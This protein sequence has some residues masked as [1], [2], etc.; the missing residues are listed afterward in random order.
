MCRCSLAATSQWTS[1]PGIARLREGG[2]VLAKFTGSLDLKLPPLEKDMQEKT[3]THPLFQALS[4][5]Y[6]GKSQQRAEGLDPSRGH[7]LPRRWTSSCAGQWGCSSHLLCFLL[8]R[9]TEEEPFLLSSLLCDW[10][11]AVYNEVSSTLK[12]RRDF[13]YSQG[14]GEGP[15]ATCPPGPLPKS[16]L[17]SATHCWT[18]SLAQALLN[19]MGLT[20]GKAGN[21]QSP[22][23]NPLN[24]N[25]HCE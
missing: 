11:K 24:A 13:R 4:M 5:L 23:A 8:P 25:P 12:G 7:H 1:H 9:A 21:G 2:L 10:T 15:K 19:L 20:P 18:L 22:L 6:Q 16:Q 17:W 14:E 3:P